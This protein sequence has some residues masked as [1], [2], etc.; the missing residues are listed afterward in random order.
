MSE[1]FTFRNTPKFFRAAMNILSFGL[2]A[3]HIASGRVPM[4]AI[5]L[6][7]PKIRTNGRAGRLFRERKHR[8]NIQKE[9][10]RKNR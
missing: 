7:G 1:N 3:D 9:S 2:I 6:S 8:R 5:T 4:S 10:R